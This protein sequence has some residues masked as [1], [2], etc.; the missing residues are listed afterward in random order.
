MTDTE[1]RVDLV[2]ADGVVRMKDVPRSRIADHDGLYPQIVMA[3]IRDENDKVLV[4]KRGRT[5]SS[6]P[7]ALAFAAGMVA[8]GEIPEQA[9]EREIF[10]ETGIKAHGL[11]L[12][13][14]G[15][16]PYGNY[17][18]LYSGRTEGKIEANQVTDEKVAW[19][20]FMTE[21]E[22]LAEVHSGTPY[23]KGFFE[24]I[25]LTR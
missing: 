14:D 3:V 13:R 2:D 11:R 23:C 1:E 9:V 10:E 15:M 8:A 18:Y 19:A 20:R 22:I 16:S 6:E 17:A 7:G 21:S 24:D 25:E 5:V 12:V 4:I